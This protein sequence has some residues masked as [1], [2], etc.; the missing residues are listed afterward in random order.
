MYEILFEKKAEKKFLSLEKKT[1]EVFKEILDKLEKDP[2]DK[3][4]NTK[5]LHTPF[6]GFRVRKGKF[7]MLFTI[8]NKTITIFKVGPRK[9]IYKS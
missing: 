9:N 4:L 8:E 3:T 1:Q 5:K 6:D 2:F 7:L